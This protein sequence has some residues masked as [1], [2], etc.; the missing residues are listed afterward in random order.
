MR[1]TLN[2]RVVRIACVIAVLVAAHSTAFAE[3]R[4][5]LVIGSNPG[6]SQDRP[7]RYA[8]NDA[9]RVRDVLVALGGFPADRVN[10]MRDPS[11]ADVRGALR[12]L[13][14]VARDSNNEDTL[15]FVY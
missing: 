13:A 4:Y 3:Q 1:C 12:R 14:D 9:E 11:T 15:V 5:A 7:L 10:L 6:W 2:A 8:D